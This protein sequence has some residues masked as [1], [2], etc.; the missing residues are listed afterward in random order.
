MKPTKEIAPGLAVDEEMYGTAH[1]GILR[2]HPRVGK[3]TWK[4]F[5]DPSRWWLIPTRDG[6]LSRAEL[7]VREDVTETV[8]INVWFM[9]ERSSEKGKPQPHSHPWDF[10]S[11]MLMGAYYEDRYTLQDGRVRSEHSISHL[12]GEA[13]DMPRAVYHE[14]TGAWSPGRTMSLMVCGTG[15]RGS[16]GHLDPDKGEHI[17]AARDPQFLA[18]LKALNPHRR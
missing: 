16:W 14:V 9:P 6:S 13:H 12:L 7:T 2:Q 4:Q 3:L 11:H 8:K 18:K 17:P 1:W 10:R 15:E 5:T